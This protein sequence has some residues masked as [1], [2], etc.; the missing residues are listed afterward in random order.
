MCICYKF[1]SN[2][3]DQGEKYLKHKVQNIAET[4]YKLNKQK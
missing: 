1:F 3:V 2:S 4:E